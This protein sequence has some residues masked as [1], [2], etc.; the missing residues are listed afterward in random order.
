MSALDK[1][2]FLKKWLTESQYGIIANRLKDFVKEKKVLSVDIATS[3]D[4]N[5]VW[6]LIQQGYKAARVGR[7]DVKNKKP[8]YIF[9]FGK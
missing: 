7:L 1:V 8:K 2:D 5:Y 6:D 4:F 3:E 9:V